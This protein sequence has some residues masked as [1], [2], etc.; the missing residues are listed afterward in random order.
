MN[1]SSY[2]HSTKVHFEFA[3]TD[4]E[5]KELRTVALP[6]TMLT[7]FEFEQ[8]SGLLKA[9]TELFFA[10]SDLAELASMDYSTLRA[11]LSSWI[12]H[13]PLQSTTRLRIDYTVAGRRVTATSLTFS[14]G[15]LSTSN[16][17]RR[18]K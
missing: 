14:P 7:K 1:S 2:S 8:S 3:E 6:A 13:G 17:W 11:M 16:D 18:S 9:R 12:E 4:S 10:L 15:T 5:G